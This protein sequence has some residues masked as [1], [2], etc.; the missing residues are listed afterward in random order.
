MGKATSAQPQVQSAGSVG[1][2]GAAPFPSSDQVDQVAAQTA[3]A[4]AHVAE[5]TAEV[6]SWFNRLDCLVVGPGLGRDPLLLD[7]ARSVIL[8]AK[9]AKMPLVLDGDGLFLVAREPELVAGDWG[10]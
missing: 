1:G 10:G 3:A 6:E 4:A 2:M 7:I 9:A 8:S 5:A